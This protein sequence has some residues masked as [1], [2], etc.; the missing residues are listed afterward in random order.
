MDLTEHGRALHE[1]AIIIDGLQI[2]QWCEA[3][4]RNNQ[5]GGL[6]AVSATLAVHEGFRQTIENIVRWHEM[7]EKHADLI[8][9]VRNTSHI[10]EAKQSEKTG[11]I[12]SFQNISPIEDDPGLLSIFHALGVRVIQLTYMQGNYAGQGCLERIDSGLTNFGLEIIEEMNRLGIL[13]D[14]SHVGYRTTMDAVEA[15]RQPVAF[16]HANP[17]SLWDHPRNKSDEQIRAVTRKGGVIGA[18]I[19]PAFLPSGNDATIEEY[20]DVIDHLVGLTGIEHVAVGTDFTAYQSPGFFDWLL[21]GKSR[22]GPTMELEHP[23]KNPK[24]IQNATDF[25]NITQALL[26]RGYSDSDTKKIMGENWMRLYKEV[27]ED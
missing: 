2:S 5:K 24:G 17:R 7:F 23:L 6:T 4:F 15:S 19:F 14:L 26:N 18:N 22:K 9:P 10:L 12:F 16:T 21:T 25:P 20:I 1:S 27:W 13:I 8:L 11:Y 3:V